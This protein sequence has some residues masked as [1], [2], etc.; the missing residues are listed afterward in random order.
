MNQTESNH[1]PPSLAPGELFR[2]L[3]ICPRPFKVVP[4]PRIDPLTKQF[5]GEV[6]IWPL[7]QSEL[8]SAR[9]AAEKFTKDFF[10][11]DKHIETESNP[12]F[13]AVYRD[14]VTVEL[15]CRACREPQD[16]KMPSFPAPKVA[17]AT[18]TADECAVLVRLYLQVQRECGPVVDMM[19]SDEM[20]AWL[21]RLA[22]E[23][24][25]VPLASLASEQLE[26]LVMHS[27]LRLKKLQTDITSSG[28][29]HQS[30]GT[31]YVV[32]EK[33]PVVER[34]APPEEEA[35]TPEPTPEQD[36]KPEPDK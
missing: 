35:V 2:L 18:L 34:D 29:P 20:D 27:A 7:T 26:D 9:V 17:R 15:L 33:P 5:I 22:E 19:T 6:A 4:F 36:A 3:T 11:G 31:G 21:K 12:G 10:G 8:M 28:L 24:S 16:L 14:A 23:G 25:R 13:D 32:D 1:G 30:G